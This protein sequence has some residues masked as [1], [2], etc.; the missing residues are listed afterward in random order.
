MD[1]KKIHIS[2]VGCLRNDRGKQNKL[3]QQADISASDNN[4]DDQVEE[5]SYV[6]DNDTF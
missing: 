4:D 3:K 2:L 5:I 1:P 6:D